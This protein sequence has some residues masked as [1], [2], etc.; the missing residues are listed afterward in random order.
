MSRRRY[1]YR[2]INAMMVVCALLIIGAHI[3]NA[4]L[5]HFP[6]LDTFCSRA[7]GTL[8]FIIVV[9][10]TM[11]ATINRGIIAWIRNTIIRKSV[12]DNLISIGAY[13]IIENKVFVVVPPIRVRD[14]IIKIKIKNLKIRKTVEQY[15]DSFNTAL[16]QR[17]VVEEYYFS[18]DGNHLIIRYED[19]KYYEAEIYCLED[20]LKTISTCSLMEL[21][22]DRKHIINLEE[23]PH[24]LISGSSG[25][26]KSV[27]TNQLIIQ[28]ISKEYEVVICDIKRTYGLYKPFAE[29]VYDKVDILDMLRSVEEEMYTRMQ[30][31]ENA[32][33]FNPTV[34]AVDIGLKPKLIVIEEYISLIN[35]VDKKDKEE[36]ERIV[37]N[38]SVLARQSGIH[39]IMV[40]QSAGTENINSTTRSNLTKILLG[41]AQSNIL[42]ATF[43]TGIHIPY[44]DVMYNRGEGLIQLDKVSILRVPLVKDIYNLN[45]VIG[46]VR[47]D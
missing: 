15:L 2:L 8:L 32:L 19:M 27:L 16:P 34:T 14:G 20:Y 7:I 9:W 11:I 38:L 45:E 1:Y 29:Y 41:K 40:M 10:L 35:S 44:S 12:E 39:L 21:Y 43:G 22:I 5:L 36:I 17:F 31:L 37:K 13:R 25:T 3:A 26:G 28:A 46:A 23:Y 18:K 24:L 42:T 6:I 30:E 33:D 47:K 4:Y